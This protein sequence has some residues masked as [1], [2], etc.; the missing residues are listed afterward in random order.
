[1]PLIRSIAPALLIALV[2]AEAPHSVAPTSAA[3]TRAASSVRTEIP[4]AAPLPVTLLIRVVDSASRLPLPNAEVST[5]SRR[6]LT[7]AEGN[8]RF[9]WPEGGAI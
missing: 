2:G 5:P 8:V 9:P 7:D 1:M 3:T 6:R 4:I